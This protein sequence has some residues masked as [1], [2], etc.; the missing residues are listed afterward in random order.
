[1]HI[2]NKS[3]ACEYYYGEQKHVSRK[4]D[5]IAVHLESLSCNILPLWMEQ[6]KLHHWGFASMVG[7]GIWSVQRPVLR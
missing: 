4:K 1:M 3:K 7:S 6:I 5:D 2:S